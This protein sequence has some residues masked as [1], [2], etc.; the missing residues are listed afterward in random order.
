MDDKKIRE[1]LLERNQDFRDLFLA[2]QECE[3]RL[4]VIMEKDEPTEA[5]LE[6]G[7]RLK[8]E[9]LKIKDAMQNK[10]FSFKQGLH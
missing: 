3:R 2:H 4:Q 7:K 1:I 6:H 5:D 10:I 9:K 8:V